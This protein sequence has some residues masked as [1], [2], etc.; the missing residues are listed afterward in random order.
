MAAAMA[1]GACAS[2]PFVGRAGADLDAL[3][4]GLV[5]TW[6]NAA[7]FASAPDA[8]KRPPAPGH[9]YD[10][11][12]L[13][14][15]QFARVEAANIGTHVIYLEWRSGGPD[16]PVSR[17]RLWSFR[18]EADGAVRMD[19]FAFR[20]PEAFVGKGATPSAFSAV[21][22]DDLIGYGPACALRV[23]PTAPAAFDAEIEREE[24]RI[25]AQS[26]R[27]MGIAARVTLMST[28][29][30][31]SEEGVLDDETYAFKVPGGP[32]YDFRRN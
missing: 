4:A 28:G 26:G 22:P 5:G 3:A 21:T 30:L 31:Y 32:P 23:T 20:T 10:W 8:L 29:L 6:S 27:G 2:L 15:A 13:Q 25:T 24:C 11:L 19:F 12:D 18:S 14:H 7:Q 17:Q 1:L 16:G 9:P